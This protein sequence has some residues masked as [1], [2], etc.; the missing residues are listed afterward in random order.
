VLNSFGVT[1]DPSLAY[2]VELLQIPEDQYVDHLRN[3]ASDSTNQ[4]LGA[5][6]ARIRSIPLTEE[7]E[8]GVL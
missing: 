5:T 6:V 3:A 1:T 2:V 8:D 7:L 4:K